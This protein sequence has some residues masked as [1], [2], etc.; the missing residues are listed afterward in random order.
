MAYSSEIADVAVVQIHTLSMVRSRAVLNAAR[1]CGGKGAAAQDVE[2]CVA[3]MAGAVGRHPGALQEHSQ[4]VQ[5][6]Q[7]LRQSDTMGGS[8][9][10]LVV[11]G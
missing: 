11:E 3:A 7:L 1:T 10:I 4:V 5:S 8:F 6:C 9:A 2:T